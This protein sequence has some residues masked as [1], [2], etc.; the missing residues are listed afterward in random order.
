MGWSGAWP[1]MSVSSCGSVVAKAND[2]PAAGTGAWPV[3][4]GETEL[5]VSCGSGVMH[6]AVRVSVNAVCCRQYVCME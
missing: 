2:A 5:M 4:I 3:G 6:H 1:R